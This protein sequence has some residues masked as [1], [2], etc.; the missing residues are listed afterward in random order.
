MSVPSLVR[1]L[2]PGAVDIIGDVHGEFGALR[3]L[4]NHLGYRGDGT[5]PE[6][7]RPVFAGDLTDRGPDNLPVV[8][9]VQ[10]LVEGNP[11]RAQAILGNHDLNILL[12]RRREGNDW[13]FAEG[14]EQQRRVQAFFRTL[15]LVLERPDLRV[16]HACWDAEMIELA[17]RAGDAVALYEAHAA[18][19]KEVNGRDPSLDEVGRRLNLQNCNPVK[20]LTSGPEQRAAVPFTKGGKQRHE[21]RVEWWKRYADPVWCVFGHYAIPVGQPHFF[22]RA[23]CIDYGGGYRATERAAPGFAGTFTTRL[24][25]ARFPEAIAIFDD[26]TSQEIAPAP[27]RD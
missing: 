15:P 19:I 13:F 18:R 8:N 14:P 24:G 4:L 26:G 22:G 1:P 9:L 5:H 25:A 23:V 3:D 20:L 10:S 7:R 27:N 21:E 11:P 2:F 17:R 6:G 12:D 16:V